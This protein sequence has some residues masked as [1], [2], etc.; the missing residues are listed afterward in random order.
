MLR[1]LKIACFAGLLAALAVTSGAV[2][3][4][5]TGGERGSSAQTSVAA[6]GAPAAQRLALLRAA[7][8]TTRAGAQRYL[9]A[10]GLDPRQVVIQRGARNYAG[11]SCPGKGWSCTTARQVLQVGRAN[12]YFCSPKQSGAS[13]NDCVIVQSGGGTATCTETSGSN[14]TTQKCS[15][16]QTNSSTGANNNALV[17]QILAQTAAG[18]GTQVATQSTSIVQDNTLGGS[19]LVGV[20]QNVV[21]LLGRGAGAL[22]DNPNDA[23]DFTPP[24]ALPINQKQDAYQRLS[25]VQSTS[26]PTGLAGNNTAGILQTQLQRAR[27]DRAPSITQRQNTVLAPTPC[28]V[29]SALDDASANQCASVQQTS[30][31][32]PNL[33]GKNT[34][35]LRQDYRQF[36]AA[37]NC[38]VTLGTQVQGIATQGGLDHGFLES[39]SGLST[40]V[41]NQVER[42]TQRRSSIASPGLTVEQHGPTR[43]GTGS[44]T[45]NPADTAKQTQDSVQIS[46]PTSGVVTTNIV[47]DHCSSDGT[48][49]GTQHVDSNGI[50]ENNTQTGSTI[51]IA[52]ACAEND[53][54]SSSG[55]PPPEG[56]I[57]VPAGGSESVERTFAVPATPPSADIEIAIDTTGSMGP[58]IAQAQADATAI[59]TGVQ[60]A[61]PNSQFA[62]VDFKDASDGPAAEYRIAQSMT[63]SSPA[64]QTAINS[65]SAGGGGDAPEAFNLVFHNS[66]TPTTGG[67]LGWRAGTRKFVVVIGDAEPHG[68]GTAGLAGCGD[69]TVDPHGFNTATELA[70]MNTNQRTLFMILQ[71]SFASTTLGCYQSLAAAAFAGGQGVNGGTNLATQIVNLINAATATVSDVHLEVAS[72]SPAPAAASWISFT[73]TSVGPVTP[74]LNQAFTI[75]I[76]VPAGTPPG[77]YNFDIVGLA[78]GADI[79]H[80]PLVVFVPG[81]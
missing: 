10:I 8:L 80:E 36:Q 29:L 5:Q 24:T 38:C 48:C 78:D 33:G 61:I 55:P 71:T 39:S 35:L 42:Q 44:Q 7:D 57:V 53:C 15:I 11:S 54:E 40:Q 25:I 26:K 76:N 32:T 79:G 64:V 65:L 68:A 17:V 22:N 16:T 58:S 46:T 67:D 59:V 66:Y 34:S 41:S 3:A 75:T 70:G 72:A 23:D 18:G 2:A 45:G 20:T 14:M 77:T 62:V 12:I 9:R 21:Q 56:S 52:V 49:T 69:T 13:P 43:K 60:A 51:T 63:S 73:P 30:S 4:G 6:I 28:P 50:V 74:P 37:S 31:T 1:L 81:G 27:A 47:T 19:N